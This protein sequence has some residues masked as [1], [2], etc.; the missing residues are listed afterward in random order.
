MGNSLEETLPVLGLGLDLSYS[1]G[2][3]SVPPENL[4]CISP[5]IKPLQ[6]I[7][8]VASKMKKKYLKVLIAIQKIQRHQ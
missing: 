2:I 7:F 1:F 8:V 5:H 6:L 4:D 3:Y